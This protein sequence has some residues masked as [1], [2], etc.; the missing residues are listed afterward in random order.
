MFSKYSLLMALNIGKFS[1]FEEYKGSAQ[2]QTM[3][4][5][6]KVDLDSFVGLDADLTLSSFPSEGGYPA[7]DSGH[8]EEPYDDEPG[9]AEDE[10][11][12]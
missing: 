6:Y 11:E 2:W 4:D 12:Q 1:E 10:W 3:Q 9:E 8:E 5:L 7:G